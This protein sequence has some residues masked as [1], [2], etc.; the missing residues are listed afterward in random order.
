MAPQTRLRRFV[1]DTGQAATSYGVSRLY[2]SGMKQGMVPEFPVDGAVGIVG[3]LLGSLRVLGPVSDVV[4]ELSAGMRDGA[5]GR[6]GA[7]HALGIRRTEEGQFTI[8]Q[9]P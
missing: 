9:Q 3:A 5:L 8:E 6:M 4:R 2:T 7:F 1:A